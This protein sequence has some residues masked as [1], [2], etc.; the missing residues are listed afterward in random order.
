[1]RERAFGR[2]IIIS[3][4]GASCLQF[5]CCCC[6]TLKLIV[7]SLHPINMEY[8]GQPGYCFSDWVSAGCNKLPPECS[9]WH[10]QF[11]AMPPMNEFTESYSQ[12]AILRRNT[13]WNLPLFNHNWPVVSNWLSC[14][15]SP[16]LS[17]SLSA[18]ARDKVGYDEAHPSSQSTI[19]SQEE[20]IQDIEPKNR[21]H[22]LCNPNSKSVHCTRLDGAPHTSTFGAFCCGLC[23]L[24][25]FYQHSCK[26]SDP[27]SCW[28]AALHKNTAYLLALCGLYFS[29][30]TCL[31]P[32]I[33]IPW[34]LRSVPFELNP[35]TGWMDAHNVSI[36]WVIWNNK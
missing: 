30:S 15:S 34:I 4:Q 9:S 17:L 32:P 1:M 21:S 24:H 5:G 6:G 7:A 33:R 10:T 36:I 12:S 29:D 16:F 19:Y 13:P 3:E 22:N 8:A 27:C 11:N 31:I 26:L 18:E 25:T 35:P 28:M 14:D 20:Q 2:A 23:V